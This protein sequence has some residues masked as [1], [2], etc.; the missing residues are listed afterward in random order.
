MDT[1]HEL[2]DMYH[3]PSLGPKLFEDDLSSQVV[4]RECT[5]VGTIRSLHVSLQHV[6][7]DPMVLYCADDIE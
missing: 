3:L 4:S 1:S 5:F 2:L 6:E 7:L